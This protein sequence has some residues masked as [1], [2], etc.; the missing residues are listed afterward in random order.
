MKKRYLY[1]IILVI[2]SLLV[3]VLMMPFQGTRPFQDLAASEISSV[4]VELLPPDVTLELNDADIERLVSILH[5]SVIYNKDNSYGDYNGQAVIYTITMADGTQTV[6]QAYNPFLVIG[7]TGYKTKYK[8]CEELS[9]LGNEIMNKT[10]SFTGYPIACGGGI[11]L[12][13]V[14]PRHF[15]ADRTA[16]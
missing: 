3:L 12:S 2:A 5:T 13:G 16:P 6:V 8:P 7:G 10:D 9:R 15:Q 14:T 11:H 1:F 4:S